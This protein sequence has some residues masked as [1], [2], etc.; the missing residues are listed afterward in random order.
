MTTAALFGTGCN[1]YLECDPAPAELLA[2]LAPRLSETGLYADVASETLADG[3][4]RFEPRFE[5]WS[6]GATKRRWILLPPGAVIDSA[7]MDDWSFPE[8]TKLWKEFT[9]DGVRVETRLLQ[10]VGPDPGDWGALAYVW[11]DAGDDAVARPEGVADANGTAHDVPAAGECFAC[12][13]GRRSAVLG[14]SAVQLSGTGGE[15]PSLEQLADDGVLSVPP[16]LPVG[17]PGDDTEQAAL[18]YL[19]ANCSHCHNQNRPPRDGPRCFDPENEIDF[20]LR[21]GDVTGEPEETATYLSTVGR[22]IEPGR[23][24]D[25]R[26]I[27]FVS[28]RGL[29]EQMP[30]LATEEVDS[31]A[32]ALLRQWITEMPR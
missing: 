27:R 22:E 11:T 23:P 28:R 7:D 13:G 19:H 18:G 6:D 17:V 14:F 10:K 1:S 8:G 25:S 5:L 24:D 2:S 12:H 32:L 15:G 21:A 26:L 4:V 3:V 9:R 31:G 16:S 29:F 20:S 30:P